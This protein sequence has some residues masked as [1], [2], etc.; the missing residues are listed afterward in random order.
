MKRNILQF[1][2]YTYAETRQISNFITSSIISWYPSQPK[3]ET[4]ETKLKQ[5]VETSLQWI[6]RLNLNICREQFALFRENLSLSLSN[7][8]YQLY[9]LRHLLI[10]AERKVTQRKVIWTCQRNKLKQFDS[11][12]VSISL[13]PEFQASLVIS[14]SIQDYQHICLPQQDLQL[15]EAF[16][17][18][19]HNYLA[20]A[21]EMLEFSR[22][23]TLPVTR[24][25]KRFI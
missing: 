9:V 4:T 1:I 22:F 5:R 8:I 11:R 13:F 21:S 2:K 23:H 6:Y 18:D 20:P 16:L 7:G 12:K 17:Y 19:L 14:T 24:I 15:D 25:S 10:N 3:P